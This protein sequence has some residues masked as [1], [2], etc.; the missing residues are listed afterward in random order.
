MLNIFVVGGKPPE[1]ERIKQMEMHLAGVG[2]TAE[3][4]YFTDLPFLSGAKPHH[5]GEKPGIILRGSDERDVRVAHRILRK[6][7]FFPLVEADTV[8]IVL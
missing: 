7:L 4:F 5:L 2:I 6:E 8:K 3:F 1:D